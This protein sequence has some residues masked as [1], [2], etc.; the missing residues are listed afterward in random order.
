MEW[1]GNQLNSDRTVH[2]L[3]NKMR[4]SG[5]TVS[6]AIQPGETLIAGKQVWFDEPFL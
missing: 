4:F 5:R 2:F 6:A 3:T 1:G